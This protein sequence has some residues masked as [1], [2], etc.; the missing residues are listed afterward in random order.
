M[1]SDSDVRAYG[2][3]MACTSGNSDKFYRFIVFLDPEPGMVCLYG[4]RHTAGSANAE[5]HSTAEE[6][7]AAAMKR[8][9]EKERHDYDLLTREFTAFTVPAALAA[10]S[11]RHGNAVELSRLFAA[12]AAEQGHEEPHA[13]PVS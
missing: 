9:R 5:G 7:I 8:T 13:S 12:A 1:T 3:E 4:R 11:E 6:T 10:L 2:W